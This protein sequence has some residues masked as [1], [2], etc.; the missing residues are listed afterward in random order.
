VTTYLSIIVGAAL[1]NN[2]VLVQFLGVSSLFFSS[3]RLQSAIELALFNFVVMFTASIINLFLYHLVLLPLGLEFLKLLGFVVISS[4]T[5]TLLL[6]PLK[7]KF[8]LSLRRQK[9]AF[10]LAGGNSAV[11]GIAL[12]NSI[13]TLN[14]AQSIAYGFGAAL[15]FSLL[16]IAFAALRQRL[17]TSDTPTPFRGAAIHLISAGIVTMCLLGFAGLA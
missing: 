1:V 2:I 13:S 7:R 8:P 4:A 3:N 17:D 5:A 6:Q 9:L 11:L 15:G 12:L 14:I 16:L 10:Y